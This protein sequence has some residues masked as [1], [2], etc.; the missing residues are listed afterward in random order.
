MGLSEG[1]AEGGFEG[2]FLGRSVGLSEGFPE[3]HSCLVSELRPC[4]P[5]KVLAIGYS[6]DGLLF[7]KVPVVSFLV[8]E[9]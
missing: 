1:F 8:R 3:W 4:R 5:S 2:D 9:L 6:T 7:C